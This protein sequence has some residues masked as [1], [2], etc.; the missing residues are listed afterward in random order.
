MITRNRTRYNLNPQRRVMA[1]APQTAN[2]LVR[3]TPI[4]ATSI[5]IPAAPPFV[6]IF[7]FNMPVFLVGNLVPQLVAFAS[8]NPINSQPIS[9]TQTGAQEIQVE[10]TAGLGTATSFQVP[11]EDPAVRNLAGAYWTGDRTRQPL[12]TPPE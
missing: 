6:A 9:A 11:F 10:F 4:V 3:R 12:V 5:I 2:R 7:N 1:T 8:G